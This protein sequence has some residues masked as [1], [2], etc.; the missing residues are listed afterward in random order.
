M[1]RGR[2]AYSGTYKVDVDG[3]EISQYDFATIPSGDLDNQFDE[4]GIVRFTEKKKSANLKF[5]FVETHGD[6]DTGVQYLWIREIK[7]V[8]ILE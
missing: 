5:T 2:N 7:L 4:I 3:Q 6:E 8:P 1:V